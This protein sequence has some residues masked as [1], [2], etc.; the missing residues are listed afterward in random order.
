[1]YVIY[2]LKKAAS[3]WVG[4]G[5]GDIYD[6]HLERSWFSYPVPKLFSIL[7][8]LQLPIAALAALAFLAVSSRLRPLLPFVTVCAYFTLVHMITW[9]G[10]RYSEPLSPLLT[11]FLVTSAMKGFLALTL[12]DRADDLPLDLAGEPP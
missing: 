4:W 9:S 12:A 8:A 6:G 2:S 11:I 5:Y 1:M 7:V 10:M 3:L